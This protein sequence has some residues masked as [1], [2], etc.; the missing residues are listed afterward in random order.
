MGIENGRVFGHRKC[1]GPSVARGGSGA[2]GVGQRWSRPDL[3]E[4]DRDTVE[5]HGSL[6]V[7][8]EKIVQ[9]EQNTPASNSNGMIDDFCL[10]G[11]RRW[12]RTNAPPEKPRWHTGVVRDFNHPNAFLSEGVFSPLWSKASPSLLRAIEASVKGEGSG[13]G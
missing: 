9:S 13:A 12:S 6:D 7:V 5:R 8:M 10:W 4:A 11:S 2:T 3:A 1:Q